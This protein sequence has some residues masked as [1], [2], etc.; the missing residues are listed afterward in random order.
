MRYAVYT[1]PSHVEIK[2]KPVPKIE[3]PGDVLIKVCYAGICD[4]DVPFF[5]KDD[6]LITWPLPAAVAGHEF[7]GII[8]DLGSDA[9]KNGFK[10]GNWVSGHAWNFCGTCENCKSGHA[11]HCQ[12][13]SCSSVFSEYILLNQ[14]QIIKLLPNVEPQN[15]I[16]TDPTSYCLYNCIKKMNPTTMKHVLI[17]GINTMSLI[18]LQIA[19]KFGARNILMVD[20]DYTKWDVAF[21]LGATQVLPYSKEF[22]SQALQ[23]TNYRGYDLIFEISRDSSMLAVATQVIG[24]KGA[25]LYSYMYGLKPKENVNLME[26][27]LKEA[28]LL[29]F[30]LACNTLPKAMDVMQD[31]NFTP[32]VSKIYPFDQINEAFHSHLSKKYIKILLDLRR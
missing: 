9:E 12:N 27:Y 2:D 3:R 30:F 32:M 29:P 19:V 4:D 5:L 15:G 28:E 16:F 11:N 13:I 6:S 1:S 8:E 25:I 17:F 31:I 10:K 26:L 21:Q 18:I 24:I 20:P 22:I 7:S 23:L 14:K